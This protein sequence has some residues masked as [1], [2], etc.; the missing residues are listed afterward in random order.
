MTPTPVPTLKPKPRRPKRKRM[1]ELDPKGRTFDAQSLEPVL[2]IEVVLLDNFKNL[3]DYSSL[4]NPQI[5]KRN[6]EFNFWVPNGIYYLDI[7]Q[8]PASHSWPMDIED[9]HPNYTKAYYCDPEVRNKEDQPVSL[10]YDQYT[11]IEYNKLVHCDVPLDPGHNQPFRSKVA[12]IDFSVSRVPSTADFEYSGRTSHP[13]TIVQLTAESTGVVVSSA[14]ANKL[15]YWVAKIVGTQYPTKTNGSPDRIEIV[16][17]KTDLTG[18]SNEIESSSGPVFDPILRYLEGYAY[19]HA[20]Q[21]ISHAKVGVKQ[22]NADRIV[23]ITTA[24]KNGFFRIGSQYLPSFPYVLVF[25]YPDKPEE[26]LVST[27][28]FTDLNNDYLKKKNLNLITEEK[29]NIPL[30]KKTFASLQKSSGPLGQ[31]ADE[32]ITPAEDKQT[33]GAGQ[34]S[35][36]IIIIF[37]LVLAAGLVIVFQL[38]KSK[39]NK[40]PSGK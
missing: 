17:L 27:S 39:Q 29:T 33:S 19:D 24:D 8:K 34:S 2:E 6:G 4:V 22:K 21:V 18:G 36:L 25:T 31:V 35:F 20:G 15:G 30:D 3:F 5:V 9:V 7:L 11:I 40:I 12:T 10:Y 16:Y 1:L 37:L 26:I 38:I 32:A 23:Y 13:L 14:S 28:S